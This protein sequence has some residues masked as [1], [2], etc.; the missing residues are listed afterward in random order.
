MVVVKN[1]SC[2]IGGSVN[3]SS[4]VD[5]KRRGRERGH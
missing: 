5:L 1:F 4:A 2:F 3:N